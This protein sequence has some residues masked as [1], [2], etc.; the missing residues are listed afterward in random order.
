MN[1]FEVSHAPIVMLD[2]F[3]VAEEWAGL[4]EYAFDHRDHF[5]ATRVVSGNGGSQVDRD[6]RRSR[7]L[8]DVGEY[9]QLFVDRILTHLPRVLSGLNYPDF[10]VSEV[11]VQ[12]TATGDGEFF[13]RHSDSGNDSLRTRLITFVYFFHREPRPF[14]GGEFCI[15]GD[16]MQGD[17]AGPYAM[18][19]PAQNQILFFA[20]GCLHEVLPVQCASEEIY[21]S[22]LTVNGWLHA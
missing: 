15:Y 1:S 14:T 19:T 10:P 9:R 12:L 3:L 16:S 20:S 17:A 8:F 6:Y 11:E 5:S 2:E 22:R 13:R 18:I 7:V 21:D 4:M